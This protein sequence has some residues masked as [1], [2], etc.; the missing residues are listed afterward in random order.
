MKARLAV[1][2]RQEGEAQMRAG[3]LAGSREAFYL[4]LAAAARAGWDC[5]SCDAVAAHLQSAN[6]DGLLLFSRCP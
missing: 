4:T 6:F 2:G 5:A 3:A 1:Q